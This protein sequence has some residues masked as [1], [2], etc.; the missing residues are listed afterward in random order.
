MKQCKTCKYSKVNIFDWLIG[1]GQKFAKCIHP[2]SVE[3]KAGNLY[4]MTKSSYHFTITMRNYSSLCG[5]EGKLWES[6]R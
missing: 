3:N 1:Y 5:K 4:I 2:L 6:K